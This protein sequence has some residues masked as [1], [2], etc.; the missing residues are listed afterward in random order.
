[1]EELIKK[2][3][4][5]Q[6]LIKAM[7]APAAPSPAPTGMPV[8]PPTP[9]IPPITMKQKTV[10]APK[11][12]GI[13]PGSK[14]DPKKVA[15]Q[16]K[17]AQVQKLNMPV[18]KSDSD[19]DPTL[20]HKFVSST[21]ENALRSMEKLHKAG[22]TL[23]IH[24]TSDGPELK[25]YDQSTHTVVGHISAHS[26]K[27]SDIRLEKSKPGVMVTYH[28]IN[29]ITTAFREF[30]DKMQ[31]G[32][33]E[34]GIK[35]TLAAAGLVGAAML[36][37]T[38]AQAAPAAPAPAQSKAIVHEDA[39]QMDQL[40]PGNKAKGATVRVRDWGPYRVT[41][42]YEAQSGTGQKGFNMN[43]SVS[44]NGQPSSEHM[45]AVAKEYNIHPSELKT[46][47]A[48]PDHKSDGAQYISSKSKIA[49]STGSGEPNISLHQ[50]AP[51]T[52]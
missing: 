48:N 47:P 14:K 45:S 50:P 8:I 35:S 52:K 19:A 17:A 13:K 31:N 37:G 12:P 21:H 36:G 25:I 24:K 41:T 3:Q 26:G 46:L 40:R 32:S 20:S 6:E 16:L 10:K 1:M 33:L 38:K 43:H 11:I 49:E 44:W 27:E 23:I 2:L 15:E 29:I 39:G 4:A 51:K 7:G 22:Y 5:A 30:V 9:T 34:K 18:L 42:T 28:D